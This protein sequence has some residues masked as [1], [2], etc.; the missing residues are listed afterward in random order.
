MSRK[1]AIIFIFVAIFSVF[2]MFFEINL[3]YL[4]VSYSF[5][6]LYFSHTRPINLICVLM[7]GTTYCYRNNIILINIVGIICNIFTKGKLTLN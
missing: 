4:Q 5:L 3:K 2:S 7:V 6:Q 1:I